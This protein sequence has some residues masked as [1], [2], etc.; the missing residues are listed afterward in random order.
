VLRKA[1]DFI[2]PTKICPESAD[3]PK[4]A[5]VPVDRNVG[6][7]NRRPRLEGVDPHFTTEPRSILMEVKEHPMLKRPPLMAWVPKPHNAQKYF[8]FR[9]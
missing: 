9:R 8:D 7:G 2:H 5:K 6:R 3:P 4:K 1:A